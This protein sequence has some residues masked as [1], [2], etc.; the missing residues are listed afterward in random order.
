MRIVNLQQFLELPAGTIFAK[1]EPCAFEELCIKHKSIPPDFFYYPI[2]NIQCRGSNDFSS[3]LDAAENDGADLAMDFDSINRDGCFEPDQ[4]FA[5]W[6][7]ADVA[8]LITKL[9]SYSAALSAV[10]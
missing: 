7:S 6:S 1:Y 9:Q 2:M 3:L 10:I 5:V 8:G 4:L